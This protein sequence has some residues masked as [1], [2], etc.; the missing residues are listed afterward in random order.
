MRIRS[1]L[2]ARQSRPRVVALGAAL[3]ALFL[4]AACG[5]DV[6]S[7]STSTPAGQPAGGRLV[8][9]GK[10]TTCTNLP[11]P[12]FQFN[13]GGKV[14]GFDVEMIDLVAKKLGVTQEI[15]DIDFDAIKG[16]TALNGGRCDVAA[17]GMTITDDRK[18]NLDFSN[19]YFDEYLAIMTEKGAG[20]KTLA[21]VKAKNLDL[22]VQAATTNLDHAKSVGFDPKQYKDSGK[23]LLA[24]Q[25]GQVDFVLQDLPVVNTWL[26][27]PDVAAKFELVGQVDT[28]AQYGFAVRK[29]GNPELLKTIN[30]VLATAIKDGTWTSTYQKWMGSEPASTPSPSA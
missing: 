11:Y 2:A 30:D 23:L 17:A 7:G 8:N 14:V 9:S 20:V 27:Q 16:G 6:E 15:V 21:D 22:G 12:P 1:G 29:G 10:L 26:K 5:V 25:S 19:P 24:L 18:K 28:G 13:Q 3:A 4:A